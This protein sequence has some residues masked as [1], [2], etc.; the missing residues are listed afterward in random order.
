MSGVL[1]LQAAGSSVVVGALTLTSTQPGLLTLGSSGTNVSFAP[2]SAFV[3]TI[4]GKNG[5]PVLTSLDTALTINA[6]VL[7][8]AINISASTATSAL[9]NLTNLSTSATGA[10]VSATAYS[11]GAMAFSVSTPTSLY[12]ARQN[13]ASSTTD[14][15][16]DPTNWVLVAS[17]APSYAVSTV[18]FNLLSIPANTAPASSVLITPLFPVTPN[19][20]Y[21]VTF[22]LTPTNAS[23]NGVTD[24]S[25][26][27]SA[28]GTV[29]AGFGNTINA[30]SEQSMPSCVFNSGVET[31]VG[32]VAWNDSTT[33]PTTI[34]VGDAFVEELGAGLAI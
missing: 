8:S 23:G 30:I 24:F 14:P 18:P 4:N 26:A 15:D 13:I 33:D 20:G 3:N 19:T 16:A 12:I 2:V 17:L 27:A 34:V 7:G 6:P 21:R 10:W 5:N 9:G 28:G 25:I 32:I 29:I 22:R 1:S 31:T 11:K